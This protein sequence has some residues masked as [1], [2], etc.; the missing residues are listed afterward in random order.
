M[1]WGCLLLQ[2][3]NCPI[4]AKVQFAKN[5][6]EDKSTVLIERIS[7][8]SINNKSRKLKIFWRKIRECC[9]TK[10]SKADYIENANLIPNMLLA[11]VCRV[12]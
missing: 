8:S 5:L 11:S 7:I 10:L 3:G 2:N 6:L 12:W 9:S 4:F 1:F